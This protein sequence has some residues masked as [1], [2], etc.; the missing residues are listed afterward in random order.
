MAAR[1]P[2][3][4]NARGFLLGRLRLTFTSLDRVAGKGNV[5]GQKTIFVWRK[6]GLLV[7]LRRGYYSLHLFQMF[8]R[9]F[10]R[11]DK[12]L[13]LTEA[14]RRELTAQALRNSPFVLGDSTL[15]IERPVIPSI[16]NSISWC[17]LYTL[18]AMLMKLECPDRCSLTFGDTQSFDAANAG[19]CAEML[20]AATKEKIEWFHIFLADWKIAGK[21]P[22]QLNTRL[23]IRRPSNLSTNRQ[24]S[25][26]KILGYHRFVSPAEVSTYVVDWM[27]NP[28]IQA[29]EIGSHRLIAGRSIDLIATE[30]LDNAFIHQGGNKMPV[31]LLAKLCSPESAKYALEL[32]SHPN[33]PKHLTEY[34]LEFFQ[35]SIRTKSPLLQLCI[36]DCGW[37][38]AGNDALRQAYEHVHGDGLE[39]HTVD[40][41]RFALS[42]AFSTKSPEHIA[43]YYEENKPHSTVHGL[44]EVRRT[45]QTFGGYWRIHSNGVAL[46][47]LAD[48][49]E[50]SRSQVAHVPGCLHY[51]ML[52]L[53]AHGQ[54][55]A[56]T[57][58]VVRGTKA[59]ATLPPVR[60]D[61]H[62][63]V[64]KIV[65]A[66]PPNRHDADAMV[67]GVLSARERPKQLYLDLARL[68]ELST[69][70]HQLI[71]YQLVH[72]LVACRAECHFIFVDASALSRS[73]LT[74]HHDISEGAEL[75]YADVLVYQLLVFI[76][77]SSHDLSI[78]GRTVNSRLD[79]CR[80]LESALADEYPD[81]IEPDNDEDA[82]LF[83]AL[84]TYNPRLFAPH[85]RMIDPNRHATIWLSRV[86]LVEVQTL[87]H[88]MW[89]EMAT[90]LEAH[91]AVLP[92]HKIGYLRLGR[93]CPTYVHLSKL[94]SNQ[95]I[96]NRILGWASSEIQRLP[97]AHNDF[98]IISVLH[99]AIDLGRGL[100][101]QPWATKKEFVMIDRRSGVRW[102]NPSLLSLQSEQAVVLVDVTLSGELLDQAV[103]ALETLGI[104]TIACLSFLT[105][106]EHKK[107]YKILSFSSCSSAERDD[108]A[109]RVREKQGRVGKFIEEGGRF[110]V[111]DADSQFTAF[112]A[113]SGALDQI[114]KDP[115][116]SVINAVS[117]GDGMTRPEER[118]DTL[119]LGGSLSFQHW[120]FGNQHS[121]FAVLLRSLT[122][123]VKSEVCQEIRDLCVAHLG[124]VPDIMLVPGDSTAIDLAHFVADKLDIRDRLAFL[125]KAF[126]AHGDWE[127]K[128]ELSEES[129]HPSKILFF[130]D[131]RSTQ[132]TEG[133]AIRAFQ[134]RFPD[135]KLKWFSYVVIDRGVR[136]PKLRDR[137]PPESKYV[138]VAYKSESFTK[139][140]ALPRHYGN[141]PLCDGHSRVFVALE[142][143][144]SARPSIQSL[145][146]SSFRMLEPR[147]VEHQ[148]AAGDSFDRTVG[149]ELLRLLNTALIEASIWIRA[150]SS[151]GR[152]SDLASP[153]TFHE[154]CAALFYVGL[155][156][157]D[158]CSYLSMQELRDL[159]ARTIASYDA[160]RI[161]R[162]ESVLLALAILPTSLVEECLQDIA[163]TLLVADK[164]GPLG[165]V[166]H[167]VL[168]NR[169]ALMLSRAQKLRNTLTAR[170]TK[171]DLQ[172]SISR[173]IAIYKKSG[174]PT[175][176]IDVCSAD[177]GILEFSRLD[178]TPPRVAK[179]LALWLKDGRHSSL[180]L[181]RLN[182]MTSNDVPDVL[183]S[184]DEVARLVLCLPD[185]LIH[186]IKDRVS[187]YQ[188][189][190]ILLSSLPHNPALVASCGLQFVEE[191]WDVGLCRVAFTG[192]HAI[193]RE[194][195]R[196]IGR[197]L[198]PR[199]SKAEIR[200]IV[201]F[202]GIEQRHFVLLSDSEAERYQ[203]IKTRPDLILI[204]HWENLLE[205]VLKYFP[206]SLIDL[207]EDDTP[208]AVVYVHSDSEFVSVV[209]ADRGKEPNS[210][211]LWFGEGAGL[212]HTQSRLESIGGALL[213]R[214]NV[215]G[216]TSMDSFPPT[217]E[218]LQIIGR[219]V[220]RPELFC[221]KF[222]TRFPIVSSQAV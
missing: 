193:K 220:C 161:D 182:N 199:Y 93:T 29:T 206:E 200:K 50:S 91:S 123:D 214:R 12:R 79:L 20:A 207:A 167:L 97:E 54:Q 99:P 131:G 195:E 47:L 31:L 41:I 189:K 11:F 76:N 160:S 140:G 117:I 72:R 169:R 9:D 209:V 63:H 94:W 17:S 87:H 188:E 81:P 39:I 80:K 197:V 101:Q 53:G 32:H 73:Y 25:D 111:I 52:P 172:K 90:H 175:D 216:L 64:S 190:F 180:L 109:E 35:N 113:F 105:V 103:S 14:D 18:T 142:A 145:L 78:S 92:Y 46:D 16:H 215:G 83:E 154:S 125:N 70:E 112:T 176:T 181:N 71:C 212:R 156:F 45:V 59:L 210:S 128:L 222:V 138:G 217:I 43:N 170:Q 122:D 150:A 115:A 74:K 77:R 33:N 56:P 187:Q 24:R 10:V 98:A 40:L 55:A 177:L 196:Q 173:L 159:V 203:L 68:D 137:T 118:W 179:T 61:D 66:L 82:E 130:D 42:G 136:F 157:S 110:R 153:N 38:F 121:A 120:K 95:R 86:Q 185:T 67:V 108:L 85:Q 143:S 165:A 57:R 178:Q 51:F 134:S 114:V 6:N 48:G 186:D 164:A 155:N 49:T 34:E 219:L 26:R 148:V 202:R 133:K 127:L 158:V 162:F 201:A 21:M 5:L 132:R 7:R 218:Q 104:Q 4:T 192:A 8:A 58:S 36:A 124:D 129:L 1:H 28:N 106:G 27:Q 135:V 174:A 139:I 84:A 19:R 213:Y 65:L 89:A 147:F 198:S 126:Q 44:S 102:D 60:H 30:I 211:E 13:E 116:K 62:P 168:S 221:N 149:H 3:P 191:I 166:A 107:D 119:V 184:L 171:D 146:K 183:S 163:N 144:D 204:D 37:G 208:L 69:R 194:I 205:N 96:R 23:N 22:G 141:C 88:M 152:W 15:N 2:S 100:L 151:M 75:K